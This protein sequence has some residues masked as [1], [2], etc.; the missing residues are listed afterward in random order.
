MNANDPAGTIGAEA[1]SGNDTVEEIP[2]SE[3]PVLLM[4]INVNVGE[5]ESLMCWSSLKIP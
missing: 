3:Y 2:Q 1:G 5:E 4:R